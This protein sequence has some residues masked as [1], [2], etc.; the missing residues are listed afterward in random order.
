[1]RLLIL[2]FAVSIAV[3]LG[4]AWAI[5]RAVRQHGRP[6]DSSASSLEPDQPETTNDEPEEH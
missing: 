1:M 6:P 5:A 2:V 3:L 4:A